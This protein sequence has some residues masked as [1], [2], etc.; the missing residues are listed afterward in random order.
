MTLY[1]SMV[2]HHATKMQTAWM[3]SEQNMMSPLLETI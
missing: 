3:E 2:R 1:H